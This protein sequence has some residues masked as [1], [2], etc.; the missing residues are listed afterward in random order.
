VE[1]LGRVEGVGAGAGDAVEAAAAGVEQVVAV[2]FGPLP[3][4]AGD[5]QAA[6]FVLELV[7]VPIT[8]LADR[9][10]DLLVGALAEPP[11]SAEVFVEEGEAPCFDRRRCA[12]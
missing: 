8:A 10:A 11:T 7:L 2:A 3:V 1:E 6:P 4:G 12:R 9:R 5:P